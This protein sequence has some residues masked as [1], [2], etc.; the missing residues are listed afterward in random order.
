MRRLVLALFVAV[1]ALTGCGG[2]AAHK[3]TLKAHAGPFVC[4]PRTTPEGQPA[5]NLGECHRQELE[6]K[7]I[8]TT[9]RQGASS[10]AQGIDISRWQ[11]YPNFHQLYGEGI[12]FVVIQANAGACRCN[13]YFDSQVRAAHAAGMKVGVYVF[14]VNVSYLAQADVL[15]QVAAPVRGLISLGAWV[16]T[17]VPGAYE[18]G[19]PIVRRL[20]SVWHFHIAGIYAS[21]GNWP[22]WVCGWAWPA[23]WGGPPSPLPG[24]SYSAMKMRQWC[25]TCYLG[26]NSGEIDRD[27]DL[28]V[29]ALSQPSPPP[30]NYTCK[31]TR[32]YAL[33]RERNGIRDL[34]GRYGCSRR[35][36][37]HERLGPWCVAE[38][39]KGDRVN[40]AIEQL[41]REHVW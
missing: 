16:D 36:H 4:H 6:Y 21:N 18:K 26:G 37:D 12:R 13:P 5:P 17:E 34:L 10:R 41:H 33:Y 29:I 3:S 1:V 39:A 20:F 2:A 19:C 40:R 23:K 7:G 32:L 22:G 38:F 27:E 9:P 11:P 24:Y 28:G 35:R 14:V 25:G 8:R 30:C 31:R 15:G